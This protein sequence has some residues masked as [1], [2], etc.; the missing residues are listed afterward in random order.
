MSAAQLTELS[1]AGELR[2]APAG[3]TLVEQGALAPH[4]LILIRGAVKIVRT[5]QHSEG[6]SSVLLDV[7]VGPVL[8]AGSS[9]FDGQPQVASVI[10]MHPSV[11]VVVQGEAVLRI[12]TSHPGLRH[13]L[14]GHLTQSF[15]GH[16]A[17]LDELATGS[18]E[19]RV[20]HLLGV[21][22]WRYGVTRDD[23]RLIPLPLRRRDVACMVNLT[24]ETV[25]RIFARLEREG[26]T[27]S[28]MDGIRLGPATPAASASQSPAPSALRHRIAAG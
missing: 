23:G 7:A 17:R 25:S 16:V 1:A 22:D 8:V 13:A 15:R 4:L 21:L 19:E 10:C 24:T 6:A 20:R 28:T 12:V 5:T 9:L 18:A 11:L 26:L 3:T 14:L 27:R 2:R